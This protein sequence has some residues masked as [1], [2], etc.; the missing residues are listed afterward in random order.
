MENFTPQI[1]NFVTCLDAFV[2]Y[3]RKKGTLELTA[4]GFPQRNDCFAINELFAENEKQLHISVKTNYPYF[5]FVRYLFETSFAMQL[6]EKVNGAKNKQV[7]KLH[8]KNL[9]KYDVMDSEE[10]YMSFIHSF[11]CYFDYD[12]R[13]ISPYSLAGFINFLTFL[14]DNYKPNTF[15]IEDGRVIYRKKNESYETGWL[16]YG[17][18]LEFFANLGFWNLEKDYLTKPKDR[19]DKSTLKG[20]Q[21]NDFGIEMAKILTQKLHLNLCNK[22]IFRQV[23]IPYDIEDEDV[24]TVYPHFDFEGRFPVL[25]EPFISFFK[26]LF[27]HVE[28]ILEK[29]PPKKSANGNYYFKVFLAYDK[30]IYRVI[31]INAEDTFEDLHLAIQEAYQFDDDHAYLFSM[32]LK[33]Y[34]SKQII[35]D[36]YYE[37]GDMHADET[38]INDMT[39]QI[40]QQILYIFDFGDDWNFIC[41]LQKISPLEEPF[42]TPQIIESV[43]ESPE[44]YE[45]E[46]E[47]ED[48]D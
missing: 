20:I 44:Q 18:F 26:P 36:P 19:Y 35:Y 25:K 45:D 15:H 29:E 40:K 4:S 31:A 7:I 23:G 3:I 41:E 39:W 24:E 33:G 38:K 46:D 9:E 13:E 43:G 16:D 42:P 22:S 37:E 2:N 10:K 5:L 27:P 28:V 34:R 32:D 6:L 17:Q 21:I 8:E 14:G 11:W 48:E 1:A 12:L 30:N 47:D